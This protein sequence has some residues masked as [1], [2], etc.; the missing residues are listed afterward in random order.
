[1]ATTRHRSLVETGG[2]KAFFR[3][4][5]LAHAQKGKRKKKKKKCQENP[6]FTNLEKKGFEDIELPTKLIDCF[7]RNHK[8]NLNRS[9]DYLDKKEF[10][11][12]TLSC[13]RRSRAGRGLVVNHPDTRMFGI[14]LPN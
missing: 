12:R 3:D 1:M 13:Q 10:V 5:G 6:I 14:R 2:R 7:L 11:S 8:S 9:V 4:K